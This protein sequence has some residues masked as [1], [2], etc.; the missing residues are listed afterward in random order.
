MQF[1]TFTMQ[2]ATGIDGQVVTILNEEQLQILTRA[3]RLIG[4]GV[5]EIVE[6]V[7]RYY[8]WRLLGLAPAAR[9]EASEIA[10]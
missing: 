5:E 2:P 7:T 9:A 4:Q 6:D 10:V 8:T 3:A 1:E